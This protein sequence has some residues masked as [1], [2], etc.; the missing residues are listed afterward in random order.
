[1]AEK[2]FDCAIRMGLWVDK[3]VKVLVL[4]VPA[5]RM[6]LW[7][8]KL[9]KVIVLDVPAIRMGLWVDKLVKVIVLDVPVP[10]SHKLPLYPQIKYRNLG[11]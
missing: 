2:A 6:G 1:M 4:D 5:I 7:V 9:V 10:E 3:L 11:E 8:D